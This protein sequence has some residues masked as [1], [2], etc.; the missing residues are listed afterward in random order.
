MVLVYNIG[1]IGVLNW[2]VP[3]DPLWFW[4]ACATRLSL[5]LRTKI[6]VWG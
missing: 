6:W 4:C 5:V 3:D 2:G 1:N